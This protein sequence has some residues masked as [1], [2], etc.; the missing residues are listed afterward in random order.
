[1]S[2]A[3][4]DRRL[5]V[6]SLAVTVGI[7][8]LGRAASVT[9]TGANGHPGQAGAP[10]SASAVTSDAS[11]TAT[12]TGG[13]GGSGGLFNGSLV[14]NG[15]AGGTASATAGTSV[16]GTASANAQADGGGGGRGTNDPS[17][18]VGNGADGGTTTASATASNT[19]SSPVTVIVF[20]LAGNGG[21]TG[22]LFNMMVPHTAPVAGNGAGAT[23]GMVTGTSTGGGAVSVSATANG[24]SGG[25]DFESS[26]AGIGTGGAG[27]GIT[28][29]N[30][31]DGTTIGSLTLQQTAIGGSAGGVD[32]GMLRSAGAASSSLTVSKNAASLTVNTKATGG[33]GGYRNFGS[34]VAGNGA[35][36]TANSSATN[37]G[38]SA[39]ASPTAFGG[40]G[41]DG[42][43]GA[44]GA[45]GGNASGT[46]TASTTGNGHAVT[47]A[48]FA[49]GGGG[50]SFVGL[51]S[52]GGNGGNASGT[53]TAT[54][55]GNSSVNSTLDLFGG[56]AGS[57]GTTSGIGSGGNG[58]NVDGQV[59]GTNAG[60]SA[61]NV[62]L[63]ATAGGGG[64]GR[65]AGQ[66]AGNGAAIVLQPG[67]PIATGTSTGGGIV[68]VKV[69][70]TA[71][72]GGAGLLGAAGGN[73]G[74]VVLT[75]A[76]SGSTTGGLNLT[77]TAIGGSSGGSE[78]A[79][80]GI[81]GN[82]TNSLTFST[83]TAT[84]LNGTVNATGGRGALTGPPFGAGGD[85][86]A[87]IRLTGPNLVN[88]VAT[89][90]GGLGAG[91]APDGAALAHSMVTGLTGQASASAVTSGAGIQLR[92]DAAAPSP[93]G[94]THTNEVQSRAAIGRAAPVA[95]APISGSFQ[96]VAYATGNPLPADV[97]AAEAGNTHITNA[98]AGS[99]VIGVGT[100]SGAYSSGVSGTA[101]I[102]TSTFNF[103]LDLSTFNPASDLIVGLDN[104]Q[105]TGSG[106][107]SLEFSVREQ[108][109]AVLDKTFTTLASATS[110]FA[111]HPMDLGALGAH[112]TPLALEFLLAV[113]GTQA[114]SG[115]RTNLIFG[116]AQRIPGDTNH[117]GS[118]NFTD[119]L[120]LAQHYGSTNA[121]WETGDFNN[122]QQVN[123]AD[124]LTLAQH[125]GFTLGNASSAALGTSFQSD[126]ATAF[127]QVPEPSASLIGATVVWLLRRRRR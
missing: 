125:Y 101:R 117:D 22:P 96:A 33:A 97:T 108:N 6:L 20:S 119:L 38:G 113:T 12:A 41:G 37:S 30:A 61:I 15:S 68:E 67:T 27:A 99:S 85:A 91:G 23:L 25:S 105:A 59:T 13:D 80:P 121:V 106:F 9:Q 92:A 112:G 55:A 82:A 110:Y 42:R 43:S 48:A 54:A 83:V 21:S 73:G 90:T 26:T 126:L 118:V 115:F 8:Q 69:A 81:A 84:A 52:Q 102:S 98:L 65:G 57:L 120:T 36:A 86:S 19:T 111:D 29:V 17:G 11:N 53:A 74:N 100:M 51:S 77:Q 62:L 60:N 114:G 87:S 124:L 47:A 16:A 75:N 70:A 78:G 107:T 58:G 103:S 35:D 93:G 123:F 44:A 10:A 24:G 4:S 94:S 71:G 49:Q 18:N 5:A 79:S 88:S 31:I 76:V 3:R 63:G 7:G 56:N 116:A 45:A 32:G 122:D 127:S 95:P 39:Q 2:H 40:A 34:G 104:P 89:S 109:T 28:L 50:G 66:H 14:L 72:N 1:M 46:A 64:N